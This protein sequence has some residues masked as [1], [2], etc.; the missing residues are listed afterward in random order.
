MANVFSQTPRSRDVLESNADVM[1]PPKAAIHH[2]AIL[3]AGKY[4]NALS[5]S[6]PVLY[7]RLIVDIV[8]I[9]YLLATS[10]PPILHH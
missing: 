10:L 2:M 9:K 6:R 8:H 7:P 3:Q 1:I 5:S 4:G